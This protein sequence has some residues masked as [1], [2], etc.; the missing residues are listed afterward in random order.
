M[1]DYKT[2]N[3]ELIAEYDPPYVE[4]IRRYIIEKETENDS[5]ELFKTATSPMMAVK[6]DGKVFIEKLCVDG[7]MRYMEFKGRHFGPLNFV[8]IG[9][10]GTWGRK[11][12]RID[13]YTGEYAIIE[14][15][16]D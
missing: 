5:V 1:I 10:K 3:N 8:N 12:I 15:K 16:N 9:W 2:E 7:K 14:E 13:V 4:G 11:Y 6:K